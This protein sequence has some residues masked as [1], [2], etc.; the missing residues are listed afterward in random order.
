MQG[1]RHHACLAVLALLPVPQGLADAGPTEPGA[2]TAEMRT[3]D[4]RLETKIALSEPRTRLGALLEKIAKTTGIALA[5]DRRDGTADVYVQAYCDGLPVA[6]AMNALWSLLSYRKGELEWHA[7]GSKEKHSYT[8]GRPWR[9]D[10]FARERQ[11]WMSTAFRRHAD[12][13]LQAVDGSEAQREAALLSIY[14]NTQQLYLG[15]TAE[16]LWPAV[17]LVK[18]CASQDDLERAIAGEPLRIPAP[19]ASHPGAAAG[20]QEGTPM[21]NEV[22]LHRMDFGGIPLLYAGRLGE[23]E[24]PIAG[25]V[26]LARTYRNAMYDA[27]VLDGD[28]QDDPASAKTVAPVAAQTGQPS[29]ITPADAS[30]LRV[31]PA[32]PDGDMTDLENRARSIALGARVPVFARLREDP[33]N[34]MLVDPTGHTIGEYWQS[35]WGAALGTWFRD[36]MPK[37]RNGILL[38][39][40]ISWPMDEVRIPE[41]IL[42]ALRQAAKPGKCLPIAQVAAV[43]DELSPKQLQRLVAEFPVMQEA[44]AGRSL[45]V[46]LHRCPQL[47]AQAQAPGG[48]ALT[49]EIA[50]L[51]RSLPG[52]PLSEVLSNPE[53]RYLGIRQEE[54]TRNGHRVPSVAF[55]G[56]DAGRKPLVGR[57]FSNLPQP[58]ADELKSQAANGEPESVVL[59]DGQRTKAPRNRLPN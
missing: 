15:L 58:T 51:L 26:P 38:V 33:R 56:L 46:V 19:G 57:G 44:I 30:T 55:W 50:G 54:V 41:R 16:R 47:V 40:T 4:A 28:G 32:A 29:P 34:D 5:A 7:E 49:P 24:V 42:S 35:L 27:W 37:W 43:A 2:I 59:P 6:D 20:Q 1:R 48:V 25:G 39:S 8:L 22:V 18:Q 12:T 3:A 17:E 14:G 52:S 36:V 13:L 53:V 23:S 31:P 10:Q 9:A 11:S 45:L 21:G